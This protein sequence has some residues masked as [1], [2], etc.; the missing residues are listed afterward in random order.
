MLN[1]V[2][3]GGVEVALRHSCFAGLNGWNELAA[4][5]MQVYIQDITANQV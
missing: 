4:A 2:P 1:L 5:L 3:W